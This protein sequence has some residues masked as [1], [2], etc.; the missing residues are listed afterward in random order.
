MHELPSWNCLADYPIAN[1]RRLPSMSCWTVL[2]VRLLGMQQV[3]RRHLLQH[4]KPGKLHSMS[5]RDI[6]RGQYW[7]YWF[8]F[9]CIMHAR[10]ILHIG[11]S[12][13]LRLPTRHFHK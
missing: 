9:L 5:S 8:H 2:T 7:L 4:F 13:V 3:P 6:Y 11:T 10:S 12:S 1:T